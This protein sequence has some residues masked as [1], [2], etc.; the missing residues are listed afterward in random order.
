MPQSIAITVIVPCYQGTN[1]LLVMLPKIAACDP[2]PNEILIHCDGGWRPDVELFEDLGLRIRWLYSETQIGPGGG[3]NRCIHEAQNELVASFD[4]DSWPLDSD[5][6]AQAHAI[7][8]AFPDAA[9]L[10]PAVYLQEKPIT[11]KLDEVSTSRYYE[12]CASIHRRSCHL[13]IHGFAPI[14]S[15]YGVEETD[16]SLQIHTS[17]KQILSSPWMRA[18]H[19]RPMRDNAHQILPW[20][21]NEVL[22]AYL[23]YPLVAQPWGWWRAFRQI[24]KHRQMI[25]LGRGIR[26]FFESIPHCRRFKPHLQRYTLS[27]VLSH[28][29]LRPIRHS[30]KPGR[31]GLDIHPATPSKRILYLQ[32]TNPG[33]YPPL[34]HSS[35]ILARRGWEVAMLGLTGQDAYSLEVPPHIRITQ[36]QMA[37]VQPGWRQKLHY[38]R[39][40]LHAVAY[41]WRF[42]PHWIYASDYLSCPTVGLIRLLYGGKL[43]YHEHDYPSISRTHA[44]WFERSLLRSRSWVLCSADLI[45][46]PNEARLEQMIAEG[47]GRESSVC[48]W[49]TPLH[50]E[51]SDRCPPKP[52]NAPITLLYH[53]S[54]V[55]AR[56]PM[57]Y[58]Q[59]LAEAGEGLEMILI[60]Y[61]SNGHLHYVQELL[62]EAE[63]LDLGKRFHYLGPMD[64]A[65]L[66]KKAVACD[67][68][69][70]MLKEGGDVNMQHMVGASNKPFDYLSQG[71]A[72]VVPNTPEWKALYVDT[73]CGV[74]GIRDNVQALCM[75][76]RWLR[77]HP[78]EVRE[79][80]DRG[81]KL[82]I[83]T[84]N[85]DLQFGPVAEKLERL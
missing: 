41:V 75:T 30:L 1:R 74:V 33:A 55:P 36:N 72:I 2:L 85:Y 57:T 84:W 63:R 70:A 77:D 29:R 14:P 6:F 52:R 9:I 11:P 24:W 26:T 23:R 27:E 22:L 71:L 17:G 16:L 54:I 49:N 15:A 67:V 66:L 48:V 73:G 45:V 42:K 51:I 40:A 7:M 35:K 64:R 61:G 58:L 82:I 10:S 28:L 46:A 56:F 78:N 34:L 76:F 47:A 53:G 32:Y 69:L 18:W 8:A 79:M 19:E 37:T 44:S 59:S 20:I 4:D 5:Y 3:R 43:L 68:G 31:H 83:S 38:L 12:G 50:D 39:Y 60:G 80:G 21:K 65:Q 81:R 62:E 13:R 25:G